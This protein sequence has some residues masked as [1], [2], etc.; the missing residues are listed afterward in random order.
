MGKGM[1]RG[2]EGDGKGMEGKFILLNM[3]IAKNSIF[4]L[5][6]TKKLILYF[7]RFLIN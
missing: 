5:I 3:N 6:L 2:W 4:K 7:K 1:G